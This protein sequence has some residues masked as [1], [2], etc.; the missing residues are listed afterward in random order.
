MLKFESFI[1][2]TKILNPLKNF[3]RDLKIIE[4]RV[5]PLTDKIG[6]LIPRGSERPVE[7]MIYMADKASLERLVKESGEKC[8]FCPGNVEKF[9]PKFPEDILPEGRISVGEAYL[10]PNISPHCEFSSVI[11]LTKKHY[12]NLDEFTP[13]I[14]VD[15]FLAIK[16]FTE[17][18]KSVSSVRFIT[19]GLQYL[20]SSG[21]SIVHPH[22]QALLTEV[23]LVNLDELLNASKKYYEKFSLNF[24]EKIIKVEEEKNERYVGETGNVKWVTPFT[25][26]SN[27][28]VLGIVKD[29]SSFMELN[30]EDFKNIADGICKILRFYNDKNFSSFTFVLNSGPLDKETPY[31]RVNLSVAARPGIKSFYVN[32]SWFLPF[33]VKQPIITIVPED[34]AKTL[35][36]YF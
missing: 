28:E 36:K 19:A 29:K 30:K 6:C 13:N 1:R 10:F 8:F 24:W 16:M 9:T 12:L 15:G 32:D 26:T 23:P 14:F 4:Y 20:P 27:Y 7:K 35:K 22:M 3:E 21:S 34:L 2:E 17:K 11:V 31:F 33:F 5:N 18:V 25:P